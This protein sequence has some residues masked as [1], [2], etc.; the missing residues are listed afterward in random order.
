MVWF[1]KYSE[2]F[3]NIFKYGGNNRTI[4]GRLLR[5]PSIFVKWSAL[6]KKCHPPSTGSNAK[7]RMRHFMDEY[8][9]EIE[10][11]LIFHNTSCYITIDAKFNVHFK[12]VCFDMFILRSSRVISK[13]PSFLSSV[14]KNVRK[15]SFF[16]CKS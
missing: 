15:Q 12:N 5:V 3:P 6:M 13:K 7:V 11:N 2:L 8:P 9:S 14:A 10:K 16:A 1:G 4:F